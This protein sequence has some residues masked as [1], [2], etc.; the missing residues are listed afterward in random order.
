L[1]FTASAAGRRRRVARTRLL[2]LPSPLISV[3]SRRALQRADARITFPAAMDAVSALDLRTHALRAHHKLLARLRAAAR[4]GDADAARQALRGARALVEAGHAPPLDVNAGAAAAL[5]PASALPPDER[6]AEARALA[7]LEA[8]QAAASARRAP[9]PATDAAAADPQAALPPLLVAARRGHDAVVRELLLLAPP[10][11]TRADP[12]LATP[13]EVRTTRALARPLLPL[14]C[15]RLRRGLALPPACAQARGCPVPA[16]L[17]ARLLAA[18]HPLARCS[19]PAR[20]LLAL[21]PRSRPRSPNPPFTL[22][23]AFI[24]ARLTAFLPSPSACLRRA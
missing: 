4:S 18:R 24:C 9:L 13:D 8:E 21:S 2:L 6:D 16:L 19:P 20:T 23:L 5:V 12:N 15:T 11:D 14:A 10:L 3:A 1:R 17:A 7:E 22:R